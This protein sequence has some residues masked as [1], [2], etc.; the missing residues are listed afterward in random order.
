MKL[1][2]ILPFSKKLFKQFVEPGS[3]VIDATCGN[4]QDTAFLAELVGDTGKVY[5]F[6]IQK[7]AI[8]KTRLRLTEEKLQSR[9]LLFETSHTN[10]AVS[11]PTDM[12]QHIC[13]TVF[14]LGY[15]PGGDSSITTLAD[16]TIEAIKQALYLTKIGGLVL[17]V[18]YPGHDTGK[19]ES[20][21]V[22]EF[23]KQLPAHLYEVLQYGF[24]NKKN[25]PP[26]IL[27]IEK[28]KIKKQEA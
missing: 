8:E 4:G 27:A 23:V 13:A 19:I 17:L 22:L 14:N 21:R 7:E 11:I 1:E 20:E 3:I 24:I 15:L 2:R 28:K 5:G 6:D 18:I 16:S 9:V 25:A 26:Y 10:M 12:H